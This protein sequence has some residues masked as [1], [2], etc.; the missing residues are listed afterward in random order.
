MK[1]IIA[2]GRDFNNYELLKKSCLKIIGSY[3]FSPI[4]I[5]SGR[6]TGADRMGE[7]FAN[8]IG[9][10][11]RVFPANWEEFG[12]S[13]GFIRNKEMAEYASKDTEYSML[14]AFWDG[15]SKGTKSMI[16]LGKKMLN[17]VE[18]VRY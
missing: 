6:A 4:E 11:L 5:I 8:E 7:K 10:P 3:T 14:I 12:K 13:A 16:E 17:K 9:Y 18:I 2:G 15:K 1:I